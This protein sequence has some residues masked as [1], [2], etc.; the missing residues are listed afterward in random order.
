MHLSDHNALKLEIKKI[1][2]AKKHGNNWKL[3]NTLLYDQWVTDEIKKEVKSFLEVNENKNMTYQNLTDTTK[4][5]LRGN[6][7]AMN[8]YIK[9]TERSHINDLIL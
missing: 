9:R 3:N 6:F 4:A 8:A 1:K 2:A 5:V 7:I